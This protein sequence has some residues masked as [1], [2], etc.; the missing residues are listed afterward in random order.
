MEHMVIAT[1]KKA[2]ILEEQNYMALFI[3]PKD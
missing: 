1:L 3:V 2:T